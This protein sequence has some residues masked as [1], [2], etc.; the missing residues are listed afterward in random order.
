MPIDSIRGA[1]ETHGVGEYYRLHGSRYRNPHEPELRAVLQEALPFW[2][3]DLSR[4]LDLACGS[5]EAT[6]ILRDLGAKD[7]HGADPMTGDA[8]LARTGSVAE[9]FGFE[10]V[11]A[12]ALEGR[13]YSL[14]VCSF[15]LHLCEP[16]RL[17][18]V[19]HQL[20]MTSPD[21]VVVTPHKRP[22]IHERWGWRLQGEFMRDRVRARW[23]RQ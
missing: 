4:V 5:G 9:R 2:S 23:Y 15:A 6:L 10:D 8:Y 13:A 1:Y 21:L 7:V 22:M 11:A 17:P 16:S 14:V 20:A 12:G 18:V 19:L 3:L